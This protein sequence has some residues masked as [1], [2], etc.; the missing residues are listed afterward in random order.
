MPSFREVFI[1]LSS[2]AG[3]FSPPGWTSPLQWTGG[4]SRLGPFGA[5]GSSRGELSAQVMSMPRATMSFPE[6]TDSKIP[7]GSSIT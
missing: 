4:T 7:Y 2:R 3:H 5:V 6:R 1:D